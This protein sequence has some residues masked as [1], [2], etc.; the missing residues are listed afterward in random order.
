MDLFEQISND[1]KEAMKAKDKV[2]LET[3][4]NVKN[5][6]LEAKTS[7]GANDTLTDE[8][9]LKIMGEAERNHSP[10]GRDKRQRHGQGDGGSLQRTCRTGRRPCHFGSC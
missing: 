5:C 7:P 8:A 2:R 9:A 6:F 4:R 1:I 3:L 10:R